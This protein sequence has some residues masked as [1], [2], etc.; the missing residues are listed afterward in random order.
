MVTIHDGTNVL[1]LGG[2]RGEEKL[3]FVSVKAKRGNLE[4]NF[5]TLK[6]NLPT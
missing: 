1:I 4:D 5:K 2:V 6:K 3:S